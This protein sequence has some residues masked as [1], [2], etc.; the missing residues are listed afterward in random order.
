MRIAFHITT[1]FYYHILVCNN[2]Q[3]VVVQWFALFP[4]SKTLLDSLNLVGIHLGS[5][6]QYCAKL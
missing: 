6:T 4:R 5:N 1:V 3:D 2:S